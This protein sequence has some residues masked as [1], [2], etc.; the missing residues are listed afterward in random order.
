[1][2]YSPYFLLLFADLKKISLKMRVVIL[3]GFIT[4]SFPLFAQNISIGE[5]ISR[6]KALTRKDP[7]SSDYYLS[8]LYAHFPSLSDSLK[9]E[10]FSIRGN[11]WFFQSNYDSALYYYSE[12]LR[13]RF[14]ESDQ[15]KAKMANNIGIIYNYS[16]KQD[17][18]Y[19]YLSFAYQIKKKI[20]D[21]SIG[22]TLNNL[23]MVSEKLGL[24][25]EGLQY[26][27]ESIPIKKANGE[28]E[29][30]GNSYLNVGVAWRV[31]K[32][33]DSAISYGIKA[34]AIFEKYEDNKGLANV[35]NNL[36]LNYLD[37]GQEELAI[38]YMFRS[39][40][41]K[42]IL[43]DKH[44]IM[45]SYQNLSLAYLNSGDLDLASAYNDS[46]LIFA[47]EASLINEELTAYIRRTRIDSARGN[48]KDAFF[49][50]QKAYDK[51]YEVYDAEVT[52]Q[53]SELKTQY[54][55]AQKEQ[56]IDRLSQENEII[57]LQTEQ[58]DRQQMILIVGIVSLIVVISI[59]VMLYRGKVRS[60]K[61]LELANDQLARLNQTKDKLFSI[62]SH[63][64]KS[65]LSS[66]HM[67]TK[68]L[69]DNWDHLEKDQ[70]KDFLITLRDSSA[71]VRD[72]MDNLLKWALAQTD[73]LQ[74]QP[75]SLDPIDIISTVKNQLM[76]VAEVKKMQIDIKHHGLVK[77]QADR[78]F[79]EI[80]IR[81]LVSNALKYSD[82]DRKIDVLVESQGDQGL[83]SIAD[84]GVG[85]DQEQIE[86]LL[87]GNLV[88]HDIQNSSEKGTGLGLLLCKELVGRMNGHMEV[89]SKRN[90]GTTFR[91]IFP[92]AA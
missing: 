65:P 45:N 57:R 61:S 28:E 58:S 75:E 27:M 87:G 42:R 41:L 37:L 51:Q 24:V 44:G 82:I 8:N 23:G 31:L 9:S 89:S 12:N 10:Y 25:E 66:F 67:I 78:V 86:A 15:I 59:I 48:Y 16:G 70:L 26:Y 52:N 73:Q 3:F 36:S 55:T 85:M 39:L 4:F 32:N 90:E 91:L 83:I 63:D 76:P 2:F 14:V 46:A 34:K 80:I 13:G 29:K 69:T 30:L 7:D 50:L 68:S 54:E 53:I 47:K 6:A 74:Y 43:G 88:A 17:S 72:M 56:E 1:M 38:D 18:A 62:I 5:Q 33:Y 35:F 71:N 20:N 21:P 49:S 81:N 64:L 19:K 22:G 84:Q 92:K 60:N 40:S 77:I 11:Y 79:L